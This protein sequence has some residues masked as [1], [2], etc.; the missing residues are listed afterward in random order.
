MTVPVAGRWVAPAGS[1]PRLQPAPAPLAS[2]TAGPAEIAAV[3]YA[4]PTATERPLDPRPSY[5]L[6]SLALR[7]LHGDPR[8]GA[9]LQRTGLEDYWR[10][11]GTQPDFRRS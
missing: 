7:D 8:W 2:V 4:P 1:D 6:F 11:S 10:K 3:Q 9:L 5:M